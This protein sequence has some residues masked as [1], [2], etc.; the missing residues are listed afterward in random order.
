MKKLTPVESVAREI[1]KPSGDKL[2]TTTI[3]TQDRLNTHKA[4]VEIAPCAVNT[5]TGERIYDVGVMEYMARI[6]E[7]FGVSK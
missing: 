2:K 1:H 4:V 7:L 5:K 3:I 6:D